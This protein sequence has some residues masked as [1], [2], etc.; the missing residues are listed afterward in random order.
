M[1][2][3]FQSHQYGKQTTIVS[4]I[5]WQSLGGRK[6]VVALLVRVHVEYVMIGYLLQNETCP[7]EDLSAQH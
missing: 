7:D 5:P 4:K 6:S 1:R 2:N 3:R